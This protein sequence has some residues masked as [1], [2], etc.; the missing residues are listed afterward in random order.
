MLY[1]GISARF[2]T[3]W[4]LWVYVSEQYRGQWT[5]G[6]S[7][8]TRGLSQ[9]IYQTMMVHDPFIVLRQRSAIRFYLFTQALLHNCLL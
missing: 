2:L 5:L 6:P 1:R 3:H 8:K 4:H 7:F 9:Q